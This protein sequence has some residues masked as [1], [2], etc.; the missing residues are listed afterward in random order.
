M[1]TALALAAPRLARSAP[2]RAAFHALQ[3]LLKARRPGAT[4]EPRAFRGHTG[5]ALVYRSQPIADH[6]R[7]ISPDQVLGLMERRGMAQPFLFLLTRDA[8]GRP[9]PRP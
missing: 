6:L 9:F 2:S 5:T 3:P 8:D 7:S 4:L 1:P